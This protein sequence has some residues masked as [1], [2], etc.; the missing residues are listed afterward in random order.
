MPTAAKRASKRRLLVEV[1]AFDFA[2]G[3]R[4]E[5]VAEG[6]LVEVKGRLQLGECLRVLR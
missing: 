3:P 4:A 5:R 1:L 2:I 6:D